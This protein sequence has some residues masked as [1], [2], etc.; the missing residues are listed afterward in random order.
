MP[1]FFIARSEGVGMEIQSSGGTLLPF[2]DP[3]HL[4]EDMEDMGSFDF[5]HGIGYSAIVRA[6]VP[7]E[8]IASSI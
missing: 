7:H 5:F 2:N 1:S 4:L 8:A 6:Q 3:V